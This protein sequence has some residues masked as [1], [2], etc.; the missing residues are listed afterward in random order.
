MDKNILIS[1]C[2]LGKECRYD[3]KHSKI[4]LLK[5]ANV[6]WI[7]VCPEELGNLGTPRPSAEIQANGKV[8][9]ESGNDLT[10]KFIDGANKSLKIAEENNC[11]TAILKSKSPS[12]GKGKIYDGSFSGKLIDGDGVFVQKCIENGINVISSDEENILEKLL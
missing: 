10:E 3:G 6:N 1:A 5:N 2:L 9:T 4:D 8:T 12:C 11:K 7:P